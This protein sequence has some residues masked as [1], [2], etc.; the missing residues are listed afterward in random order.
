[1]RF[2]IGFLMAISLVAHG[3]STRILSFD[4]GGIRGVI[5]LEFLLQLE[6]QTGLRS[7]SDFEV[8]AGTSTG[9][10]IASML[11]CGVDAKTIMDGYQKLSKVVFSDSSYFSFFKPTYDHD[12]L[13]AEFEDFFDLCGISKDLL[14]KD[15]P[16]KLV[17]PTV[18]LDDPT[19]GRWR[20]QLLENITPGSGDIPLIEA[21][22]ESTAAP[23]YFSSEAG[24]VDGG[25][26]MNDPSLA[27][28]ITAYDPLQH[29]LRDF[30][31]LAIGTGYT[32][33]AV[34][35][36]ES[37]GLLDWIFSGSKTSGKEPLITLLFDVQEQIPSQF[38]EKL[39]GDRF[40]KI[41]LILSEEI[42]LDDYEKISS[43]IADTDQYIEQNPGTWGA[44]SSWVQKNFID[45][46]H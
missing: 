22:L 8:Y 27:A 2:W 18:N 31:V 29:D 19:V 38:C 23:T 17:I 12:T 41:N 40:L 30:T 10:M 44:T 20:L 5:S 45:T 28:L 36:D 21:L 39:L 42:A 43:L 33:N 35:E 25:I 13:K 11:A 32:K 16:K 3:A 46:L 7:H 37:W 14:L 1:M 24:H 15:V 6:E 4:G 26:G 9:A 34:K